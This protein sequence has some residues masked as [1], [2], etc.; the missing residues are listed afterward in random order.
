MWEILTAKD[1]QP[2]HKRQ[3]ELIGLYE[4]FIADHSNE[5]GE[6][7]VTPLMA[8]MSG[9]ISEMQ[10]VEI[11]TGKILLDE[12]ARGDRTPFAE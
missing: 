10:A 11:M 2:P 7:V 6:L 9:E 4:A 8:L 3:A 5:A 1:I 12:V